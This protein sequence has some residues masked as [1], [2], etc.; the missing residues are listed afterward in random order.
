VKAAVVA[1]AAPVGVV[2][3]PAPMV[4]APVIAAP[5]PAVVAPPAEASPMP[6]IAHSPAATP[7]AG[8]VTS[9]QVCAS[10]SGAVPDILPQTSSPVPIAAALTLASSSLKSP[11]IRRSGSAVRRG[12]VQPSKPIIVLSPRASAP[13]RLVTVDTLD[14]RRPHAGAAWFTPVPDNAQR[15][16]RAPPSPSPEAP[17]QTSVPAA[18]LLR[19]RAE[20]HLRRRAP[21]PLPTSPLSLYSQRA[22][23]RPPLLNY[24]PLNPDGSPPP[25]EGLRAPQQRPLIF[26]QFFRH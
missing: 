16:F 1:P 12:V 18:L 13:P 6:V 10:S 14:G 11:S 24:S 25:L 22:G 26:G 21:S 5:A 2:S 8:G 7:Y 20:G 23:R 15:S 9:P 17:S 3:E 4:A 19:S